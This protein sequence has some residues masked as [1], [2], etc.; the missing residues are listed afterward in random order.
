[1]MLSVPTR[2]FYICFSCFSFQITTIS[3]A[4]CGIYFF[5]LHLMLPLISQFTRMSDALISVG[6]TLSSKMQTPPP[7][8][9][10]E[11][12][13]IKKTPASDETSNKCWRAAGRV[14]LLLMRTN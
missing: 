2:A 10:Q 11:L 1:M 12:F 13:L 9:S 14:V 3:R 6:S 7:G 8:L 5:S 4:A